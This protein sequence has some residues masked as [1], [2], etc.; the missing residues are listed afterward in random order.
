MVNYVVYVLFFI[1]VYIDQAVMGLY[2]TLI[3]LL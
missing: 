3:L 2:A 1:L